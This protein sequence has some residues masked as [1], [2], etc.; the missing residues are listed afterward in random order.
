MNDSPRQVLRLTAESK[1]REDRVQS[2]SHAL[3][4]RSRMAAS[5]GG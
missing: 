5:V 1:V 4:A 3:A 2:L